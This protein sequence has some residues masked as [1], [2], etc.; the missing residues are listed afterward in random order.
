MRIDT[1]HSP[2]R[3]VVRV[4]IL[5][6]GNVSQTARSGRRRS[7][8]RIG[9]AIARQFERDPTTFYQERALS[10]TKLPVWSECAAY[11]GNARARQNGR[12]SIP[13]GSLVE[14]I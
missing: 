14:P 10:T 5:D 2:P 6:A 13:S 3:R 11:S 7:T 12:L 9:S 4:N 8:A 1:K